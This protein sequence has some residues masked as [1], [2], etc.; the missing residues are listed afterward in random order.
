MIKTLYV[1]ANMGHLDELP[2]SGGQT[3]ARR[4]MRGFTEAGFRV[5]PIRRHRNECEGFFHFVEKM[6]FALFD[7]IKIFAKL[8]FGERSSGAFV[9]LTY[10]GPLVPFE[11]ITTLIAKILGYRCLTYLKGGQ[12]VDSFPKGSWFH[13]RLFKM[14]MDLQEKVFFE[15]MESLN[16]VRCV[17][18]TPL[19]Y[20]PNYVFE[21]QIQG[22]DFARSK[23]CV[24]LIYFGR[25]APNKNIHIVLQTFEIL[26]EVLGNVH[27][28]IIGGVGQSRCYAEEIQTLV[29]NSKYRSQITKMGNTPFETIQQ[30][31]KS[32]HFFLFPSKEVCEGHSNSLNEAMSQGVVPIVSNYHFNKSIVGDDLLV[33]DGFDAQLYADAVKKIV[34]ANTFNELSLKM[35]ERIKEHFTYNVV[36]ERICEEVRSVK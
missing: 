32:Q 36:N 6:F 23:D 29:D 28:T 7:S 14:N 22:N 18:K 9:H 35:R 34:L 15:G 21:R 10:A 20:F 16:L 11:L 13:K 5:V 33:V 1:F 30:I 25:I 4:V 24:N 3:S 2:K 31:L 8:L 17:T 19:V 26:C 12:F 27:L